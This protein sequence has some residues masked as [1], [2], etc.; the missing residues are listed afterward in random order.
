MSASSP[1]AASPPLTPAAAATR[2][3][4]IEV[5]E[6]LFRS[7]GYQKTT[8]ADI[9]RELR[10]SPANVYRFFPSKAAINEVICARILGELDAAIWAVARGPASPPDR[11]RAIFRL[12]QE[13]T[14]ALFFAE[15]RMHDMVAAALEE[16]WPVIE[17]HI[18]AIDSAFAHVIAEGQAQGLFAP[19]D[20]VQFGRLL[21]GTCPL[22]THPTLVQQC[23]KTEDLAELAQGMAEFCL[24]A[25]RAD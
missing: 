12:L 11:I 19:A 14:M 25:L 16:H 20:P 21:H 15:R 22:F 17:A 3:A 2:A 9:A 23:L 6:R 8:V 18:H 1:T 7:L 24:R 13:Q 4:I 5:A 10:M